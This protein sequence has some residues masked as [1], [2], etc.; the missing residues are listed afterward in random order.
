MIATHP[1][2]ITVN[3]A[4]VPT[5]WATVVA[6]RLGFDHDEALTLARAGAGPNAYSKGIWLDLIAKLGLR[7]AP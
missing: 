7:G 1:P 2:A 5:L 3:R 6:K 4:P